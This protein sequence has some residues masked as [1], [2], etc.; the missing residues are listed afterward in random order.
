VLGILEAMCDGFVFYY[1]D[2]E[3]YLLVSLWIDFE[4][5]Y[6]TMDMTCM[7]TVWWLFK[8]IFDKGLVYKGSRVMPYSC[9]CNTVLSNFEAGS[10]YKEIIDPSIYVTF[11]MVDDKN[12]RFL[13]WTTTPWT[14]PSNMMIAVNPELD[15]ITVLDETTGIKYIIAESKKKEVLK[16]AKIKKHKIVNKCK[17]KDLEGIEYIPLFEYYPEMKNKG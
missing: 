13:A 15:Y 3:M 9:K 1:C 11:P 10:N 4:N 12:T 5:D 7:E 16:N 14:L 17:G 8:D 2:I 6:K